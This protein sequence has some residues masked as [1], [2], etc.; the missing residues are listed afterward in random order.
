M[1]DLSRFDG[2]FTALIT[3]FT[4]SGEIDWNA[5]DALIDRQL[6]A[7]ITGLVPVGT[8]GEAATL[9]SAEAE[10]V[11][12][13]TVERAKGKAYIL[14]G[15]GSNSTE[16]TVAATRRATDLGV[17]GVLLVTPYYNKP[18][19]Q[20]LIN[21]FSAVADATTAD[22]VLYSVPGRAG[23]EIAPATAGTLAQRHLNV[24]AIKEAGGDPARVTDLRTAAPGLAV[25][26][27]DDGLALAF[28]AL[29]ACGLTS[30][31][32]NYDPEICV[33]LYNAWNAGDRTR[34]LDIHEALRDI[35][36]AMFIENSPA[37]V[38]YIMSSR[39]LN[40]TAVRMPLAEVSEPAR[41][42]LDQ[43]MVEFKTR[44]EGLAFA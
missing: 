23:V 15:T 2:V 33:A 5:F 27:G 43:H 31:F 37:P 11:I 3:P 9:S 4:A 32:S 24:V 17:D 21:H 36:D 29:G 22:V 8:T 41:N 18:S 34:A 35:A 30:V 39:G 38:K 13:H 44:R 20:G 16:K 40:G 26:C 14:A 7:G 10:A 1:S 25:H 19:Q 6:A 28:Y 12:A 42:M